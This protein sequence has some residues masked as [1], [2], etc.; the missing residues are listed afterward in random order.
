[1]AGDW[2]STSLPCGVTQSRSSCI[3]TH[4]PMRHPVRNATKTAPPPTHPPHLPPLP[5]PGLH[6]VVAVLL[7]QGLNPVDQLRGV[8]RGHAGARPAQPADA[9]G[10]C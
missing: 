3:A 5:L 6:L 7:E 10:A 4:Y 8:R 2:S 9:R 1:M